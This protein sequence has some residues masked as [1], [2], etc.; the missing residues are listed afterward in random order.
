MRIGK[1]IWY[2]RRDF[3][4]AEMA[5]HAAVAADPNDDDLLS[6]R[7]EVVAARKEANKRLTE[8]Y[9]GLREF[10]TGKYGEGA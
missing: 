9:A 10:F 2:L 5:F 3:A 1:A 4:K 6:Q 7:P 8:L